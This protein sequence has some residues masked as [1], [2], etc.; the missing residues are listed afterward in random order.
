MTDEVG[1]AGGAY[2]YAAL[3][4]LDRLWSNICSDQTVTQGLPK[5]VSSAPGLFSQSDISGKKVETFDVLVCGGTLG[6]FIATALSRRGLRVGVVERNILK[7][8]EQEWNI[9]RKELLELVEVGILEEDDI[10]QVISASFNPNRSGFEGRGE[11][12][13][14]EILNLGV[15]PV[16]LIEIMKKRFNSFGGVIFE[17]CSVSSICIHEDAAVLE[18]AE[19]K[20]LSARLIID[21]MGNFSPIVRQIRNARKPDGVCLVVG[22]CGRGF[23]NNS[24]SDVIFS[25]SSVKKVGQSKVH[26]FW[27]VI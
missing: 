23:E 12:W 6:I 20:I 27:E 5:V 16:K 9:S 2:S 18:L 26:Y 21:A 1:G 8:R 25:S 15:S 13:V 19:G 10:E 7:G 11:I 3:K 4:R 17:G 24:T 22:S 14:E